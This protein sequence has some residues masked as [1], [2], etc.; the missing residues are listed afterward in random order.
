[1]MPAILIARSRK[2]N[3]YVK[4]VLALEVVRKKRD[5]PYDRFLIGGV[6]SSR[7]RWRRGSAR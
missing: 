5:E 6:I 1:M 7:P 2:V 4:A 3:G